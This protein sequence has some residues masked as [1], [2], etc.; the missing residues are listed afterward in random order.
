MQVAIATGKPRLLQRP[1]V[2]GVRVRCD[3]D[4]ITM[5]ALDPMLVAFPPKPAPKTTAHQRALTS[6]PAAANPFRREIMAMVTG[7]LSTSA[8]SVAT[9]HMIAMP[10][11]TGFSFPG[12]ANGYFLTDS[13]ALGTSGKDGLRLSKEEVIMVVM[14][15]QE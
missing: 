3:S 4:T 13:T 6:T 9:T 8:E 5:F 7:T 14:H 2:I 15:P 12:E 1:G 11:S 10:K